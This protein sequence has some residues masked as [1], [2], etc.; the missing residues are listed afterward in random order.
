[1]TNSESLRQVLNEL[2]VGRRPETAKQL[3]VGDC[4]VFETRLSSLLVLLGLFGSCLHHPV[5]ELQ[6]RGTPWAQAGRRRCPCAG[7]GGQELLGQSC[8]RQVPAVG[9]P[10]VSPLSSQD[11]ARAGTA[12]QD[13]P[14]RPWGCS[15]ARPGTTETHREAAQVLL[16]LGQDFLGHIRDY[17]GK[18]AAGPCPDIPAP[19]L[20]GKRDF[21]SGAPPSSSPVCTSALPAALGESWA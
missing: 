8:A 7:F 4:F 14:A 21:L 16:W 3:L 9:V 10:D 5:P 13:R 12:S 19:L 1:M 15:S 20:F 17:L 6:P 18:G 11:S 2:S